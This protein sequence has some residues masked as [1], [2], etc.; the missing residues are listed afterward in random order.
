MSDAW[1]RRRLLGAALGLAG[2][3]V[4][5]LLAPRGAAHR[6][7]ALIVVQDGRYAASRGH[8]ARLAPRA[9]RVL[10]A[11]ADLARQ[12]YGGLRSLAARAPLQFAGLTSWSDFLVMRGCAAECGLRAATYELVRDADGAGHTLVRWRIGA[13]RG[14]PAA[15]AS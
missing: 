8:A 3:G 13:Q 7:S 2:T 1:S 14:S 11:R 4:I 9:L 6:A 5:A 12:W 10:E 15:S